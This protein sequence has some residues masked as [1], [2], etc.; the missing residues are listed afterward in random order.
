[1]TGVDLNARQMRDPMNIGDGETH[2]GRCPKRSEETPDA[3]ALPAIVVY[4]QRPG[5]GGFS[6]ISAQNQCGSNAQ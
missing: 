3:G 1:L 6:L 2:G 4:G 5:Y